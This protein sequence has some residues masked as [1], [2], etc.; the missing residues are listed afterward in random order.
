MDEQLNQSPMGAGKFTSKDELKFLQQIAT[1]GKF[2]RVEKQDI[3]PVQTKDMA[4]CLC[5]CVYTLIGNLYMTQ[6]RQRLSD[7]A[8][9]GG[10]QGGYGIGQQGPMGGP[11]PSGIA[12]FYTGREDKAAR[13]F[14][15]S[16]SSLTRGA[17]GAQR[18]SRGRRGRGRY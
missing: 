5:E 1:G 15:P 16:R 6:M 13:A 14:G 8:M 10:A 2:P 12:G 9:A 7:S 17:L 3:G 11:G 4:D 18:G